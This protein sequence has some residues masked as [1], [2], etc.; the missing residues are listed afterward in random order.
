MYFTS[1][2]S[3]ELIQN[4]VI[5]HI[6]ILLENIGKFMKWNKFKNL[7]KH[8]KIKLGLTT[9]QAWHMFTLSLYSWN[10]ENGLWNWL[11]NRFQD[12]SPSLW[13]VQ[14]WK[15]LL[16]S[17]DSS[18]LPAFPMLSVRQADG[19]AFSPTTALPG[20]SPFLYPN[21]SSSPHTNAEYLYQVHTNQKW[22]I[23]TV[24]K[25]EHFI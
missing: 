22:D 19:P 21:P 5:K 6:N 25:L 14:P 8:S 17:D 16:S 12:T 7:K 18:F 3:R 4:L 1:I 23:K 9:K 15:K 10:A 2:P 24:K 11:S 13:H 20:T